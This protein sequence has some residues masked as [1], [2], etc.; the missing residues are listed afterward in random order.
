MR[1]RSLVITLIA[2]A[3]CCAS[4]G[5]VQAAAPLP[6]VQPMYFEHLTM[7]D[8]LSQSTVES[9]L[10]PLRRYLWLAPESGLDRDER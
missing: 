10:Q 2:G 6:S 1:A 8:G 4:G 5:L 3:V 7:R 9:V